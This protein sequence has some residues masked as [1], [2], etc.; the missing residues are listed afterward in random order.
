MGKVPTRSP[1]GP[2]AA[3]TRAVRHLLRPLV[4][5]LISKGVQYPALSL[6][7]KDV[8]F[9]VATEDLP[10]GEEPTTSQISLITGLHR[11][12]VRK[13]RES[14]AGRDALP[15]ETSLAS[16][17]FTRWI[18]DRRYLDR[19][20]KPR[21]LPR[22]RSAGGESSFEALAER[23]SKDVRARALL[24]ELLR[25]GLAKVDPTDRV[26]L[27]TKAFVPKAG[28]DEAMHYFGQNVHDH[29]ATGVHNLLGREPEY[30][31]QA[32]YGDRLSKESVERLAELVN[33]EWR[34]LTRKVVPRAIEL[35]ARDAKAGDSG[36]RMRFGIYF[37]ADHN[38][39]PAADDAHAG[40]AGQ[41]RNGEAPP[42]TS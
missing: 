7:L 30:V 26:V 36:M 12:D 13:M 34:R 28:S 24:E 11:K 38:K 41:R 6:M 33:A 21:A 16:E 32:I 29:L 10:P 19:I 5:L 42:K 17:V 27:N 20:G 15:R 37:Y 9:E 35:D 8:Y 1:A 25:L 4:R 22:L 31:E 18:T 23:T 39:K 14:P 3:L 40:A 2:G